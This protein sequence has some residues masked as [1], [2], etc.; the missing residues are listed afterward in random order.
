[1]IKPSDIA[2]F[3]A[4]P[5]YGF[6]VNDHTAVSLFRL[7]LRL[8]GHGIKAGISALSFPDIVETR[9]AYVSI[10]YYNYPTYTHLLFIDADMDF[11][12]DLIQDMLVFDKP[13]VGCFYRRKCDNIDWVGH[14]LEGEQTAKN[15]FLPVKAI[16]MGI[17]LISR[18]CITQ[19]IGRYPKLVHD[20]PED[21]PP[22]EMFSGQQ[23]KKVFR[24]FDK[25]P[26]GYANL[27][28]DYSFCR[29]WTDMGG[30]I[31]ANVAHP[32]GHI[33][34][35]VFSGS[36]MEEIHKDEVKLAAAE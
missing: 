10:W 2:L 20:V 11:T 33:G 21:A 17:T 32:I 16:G 27:S 28:E 3:I 24:C 36:L 30:E 31:W 4:A 14:T 26:A 25:F 18:G 8:G 22:L 1:M 13:L 23:L 7:G 6:S 5:A 34:P 35:K 29:R 15:G 12:P 19:M 9:N